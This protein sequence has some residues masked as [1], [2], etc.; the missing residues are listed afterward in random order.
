MPSEQDHDAV[1][2]ALQADRSWHTRLASA[3]R[4][5]AK[6]AVDP[7]L[8]KTHDQMVDVVGMIVLHGEIRITVRPT[9]GGDHYHVDIEEL[10]V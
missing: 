8:D 5:F 3:A 10:D 7:K 4:Q 1:E 6:L 2:R 9:D